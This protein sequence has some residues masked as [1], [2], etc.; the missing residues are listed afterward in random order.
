MTIARDIKYKLDRKNVSTKVIMKG[1][2]DPKGEHGMYIAS[3]PG[4]SN[5]EKAGVAMGTRLACIHVTSSH[6]T[7]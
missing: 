1:L 3:S 6:S 2:I 5:I 7:P 4:H